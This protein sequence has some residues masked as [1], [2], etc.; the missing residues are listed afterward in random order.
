MI[1]LLL[2]ACQ[3]TIPFDEDKSDTGAPAGETGVLDTADGDTG[4]LD[5]DEGSA[6]TEWELAAGQS[7]QWVY[8]HDVTGDGLEDIVVASTDSEDWTAVGRPFT[9][10]LIVNAGGGRFMEPKQWSTGNRANYGFDVA[11]ADLNE[12]G[13]DD[14]V[15]GHARGFT[16]FYGA[17]N[18]DMDGP[19]D[20]EGVDSVG[21]ALGDVD[22][23]GHVD[24][25][26][27]SPDGEFFVW[28]G[29]GSGRLSHTGAA[30][31]C[32]KTYVGRP[33]S[34]LVD[35]D[36]DGG[37]D[38]L[39]RLMYTT[40]TT[41]SLEVVWNDRATFASA[42]T[43]HPSE[44]IFGQATTILDFAVID[45]PQF[46]TP[47]V[48]GYAYRETTQWTF[49]FSSRTMNSFQGWS[50]TF[51]TGL[52]SQFIVDDADGDGL[53]DVVTPYC[54]AGTR[55]EAGVWLAEEFA[56]TVEHQYFASEWEYE[57]ASGTHQEHGYDLLDVEREGRSPLVMTTFAESGATVIRIVE[58]E[59][60]L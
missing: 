9:L 49:D 47:L 36:G 5:T 17:E 37:L 57:R 45:L 16:V 51:G 43:Y 10:H 35:L 52:V 39:R 31:T 3:I 24:A 32:A 59:A 25:A 54:L 41:D 23:D 53:T 38:Y 44:A 1:T 20:T 28:R 13:I 2:T 22:G 4:G 12:D 7:S 19:Y 8:A 26:A 50:N 60:T 21:L 56:G 27:C 34:A 40:D 11:F 15:M 33:R 48:L 6:A 30:Q 14:A 55:C 46:G 18:G 58:A 29:D 42:I